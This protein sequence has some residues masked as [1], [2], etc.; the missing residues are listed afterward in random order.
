MCGAD[1]QKYRKN[2]RS[3]AS[4]VARSMN[5]PALSVN[6]R[7]TVSRTYPGAIH[8]A[9]G[10]PYSPGLLSSTKIGRSGMPTVRSFSMKQNGPSIVEQ[11]EVKNA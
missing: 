6:V 9:R 5:S 11:E 1:V 3:G 8:P 2:G 4:A 10:R 7:S